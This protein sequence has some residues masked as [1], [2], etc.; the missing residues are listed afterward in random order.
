MLTE[1]RVL[2]SADFNIL[3]GC[4]GLYYSVFLYH[5]INQ[6]SSP[7]YSKY[8]PDTFFRFATPPPI[9]LPNVWVS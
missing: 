8:T 4:A 9:D 6:T 7:M 5:S 2:L 1:S 3:T